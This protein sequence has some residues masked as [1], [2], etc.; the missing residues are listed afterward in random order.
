MLKISK[1]Q[2]VGY[3][4]GRKERNHLTFKTASGESK[5]VTPEMVDGWLE[6]SLPTL[7]SNYELKDIYSADEFGL[8]YKCLPNETH[9]L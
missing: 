2:M 3:D 7:L 5:S 6:T 1:P 4:V 8:F 9:Q